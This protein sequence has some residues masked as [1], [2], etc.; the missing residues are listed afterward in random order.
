MATIKYILKST[1]NPA[2]IYMRLIDG[3]TTDV[4][5]KTNYVINPANWS[6]AKQQPKSLTDDSFKRLNSD[7]NDLKAELLKHY[8]KTNGRIPITTKWLKDFINPPLTHDLPLTLIEYIDN[9]TSSKKSKVTESSIKKFNVVKHKLERLQK[10][11]KHPILIKDINR[12]FQAEFEKY[13]KDNNYAPN[14]IARELRF[15]K[16]VCR[17]AKDNGIE[18]H[19]QM[20]SIK[21]DYEKV[22]NI[23]L[24][25]KDL[26]KI[27]K[28]KLSESLDSVRDWL[29]ISCYSGQRISDF[30]RFTKSMIRHE[31]N[32]DGREIALIEFKQKKTNKIMTLP[33]HSEI[34]S[35]L[36]KRNG[37]FPSAISDQKYNEYIKTVCEKAGIKEIVSGSKKVEL[38]KDSGIYRKESGAYPKHELVSSHIGRRSFATNFYGKIPTSLLIAATGHSTEQMFL[39][40]IG[41]SSSDRAKELAEYF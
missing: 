40:Y 26:E 7:L 29:L 20:D 16:T 33:L 24:N 30:M 32:R 18:T 2:S 4:M 8:N 28:S 35:I 1:K 3:R 31:N 23:Y 13:C 10:N 38:E 21:V 15:I 5:A 11:R 9:Y 41:K 19:Y 37:E 12:T 27:K 22:N 34:L 14:T 39:N 36:G 6:K 17:H 25:E